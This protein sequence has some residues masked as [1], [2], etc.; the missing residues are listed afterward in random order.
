MLSLKYLDT[1]RTILRAAR[2]MT[3]QHVAGKLKALADDYERHA[4]KAAHTAAKAL[5]CLGRSRM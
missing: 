4:E 3:D 2:T 1:V 5:A